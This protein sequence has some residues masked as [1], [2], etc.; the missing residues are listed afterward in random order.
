MAKAAKVRKPARPKPKKT[1]VKKGSSQ[2][3]RAM[4]K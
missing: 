2:Y 4:T 3:G 1:A